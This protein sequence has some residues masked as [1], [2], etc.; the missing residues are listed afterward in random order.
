MKNLYKLLDLN[1]K[2]TA[3][4]IKSAYRK[5]AKALHPDVTG[6]NLK[7]TE[8]FKEACVAYAILSN[9]EKRIEYDT[10]RANG[11]DYGLFGT[12]F[13]D[14]VG[15]IKDEGLT[16]R[17][18]DSIIED[19]LDLATDFQKKVSECGGRATDSP[20]AFIDFIG[21]MFHEDIDLTKGPPR[22]KEFK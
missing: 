17:N 5:K 20:D 10:R 12:M 7:K 14:L 1:E 18:A 11:T 19:F 13:D 22:G 2:A 3:D 8:E 21:K 15:R 4:E 16:S 9:N 6:G